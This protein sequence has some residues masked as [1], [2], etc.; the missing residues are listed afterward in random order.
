MGRSYGRID[1]V[2]GHDYMRVEGDTTPCDEQQIHAILKR[3]ADRVANF[4]RRRRG[5]RVHLAGRHAIAATG[6]STAWRGRRRADTTIR[7]ER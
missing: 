7:R 4:P 2:T 1:P 5:A 3:C 6:A